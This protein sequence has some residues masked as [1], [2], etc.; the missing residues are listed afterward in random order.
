MTTNEA[1]AAYLNSK[2]NYQRVIANYDRKDSGSRQARFAAYDELKAA[3]I[4]LIDLSVEKIE[5]MTGENMG[6]DLAVIIGDANA[7]EECCE[8]VCISFN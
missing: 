8:K 4:D 6:S 1:K 7:R 2:Q 5:E 3:Q